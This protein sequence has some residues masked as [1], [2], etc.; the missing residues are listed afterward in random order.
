M[1]K[2]AR[3]VVSPTPAT[4]VEPADSA[5]NVELVQLQ[6]LFD[7]FVRHWAIAAL[8]FVL[9]TTAVFSLTFV[10]GKRY[11]SVAVVMPVNPEGA[12]SALRSIVSQFGAIASL[13]G[14]DSSFGSMTTSQAVALL[15]SRELLQRFV[16]ERGL[17]PVLFDSGL[18]RWKERVLDDPPTPEDA[19]RLLRK[20]VLSV[21]EDRKTGLVVIRVRW[22]D[23]KLAAEWVNELLSRANARARELALRDAQQSIEHLK[24]EMDRASA[25]EL[26][27]SV[28]KLIEAQ[29]GKKV[30]AEVRP[31]FAFR[32]LDPALPSDRDHFVS[33]SRVIF[34][35]V[36][37]GLG[38]LI[39]VVL[40]TLADRS[41][42]R[43]RQA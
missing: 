10:V 25:V 16:E 30:L 23:P 20:K 34:L 21:E 11:E 13:A 22:K 37:I 19:Y 7:R 32:V 18:D 15:Q 36:G 35:T 9:T 6:P 29:L 38:V 14:L 24:L 40:V 26:R 12:G 27:Q 43:R 17:M 3:R 2:E 5:L 31:D 1:V 39:A 4:E 41:G 42:S 33:P 28:A 8:S